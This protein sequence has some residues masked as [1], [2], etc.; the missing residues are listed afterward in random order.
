MCAFHSVLRMLA[1]SDLMLYF[2]TFLTYFFLDMMLT[3]RT[4]LFTEGE[5]EK[6]SFIALPGKGATVDS[7]PRKLCPNPGEFDE[8][9]YG[10]VS[11]VVLLTKLLCAQGLR[12]SVS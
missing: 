11:R 8:R 10:Y 4:I 6:N 9:F 7:C 12:W 3:G 2:N 5:A 1:C